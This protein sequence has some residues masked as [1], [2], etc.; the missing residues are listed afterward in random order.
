MSKAPYVG[1]FSS[2]GR[3]G[4]IGPG[5][6]R[7]VRDFITYMLAALSWYMAFRKSTALLLHITLPAQKPHFVAIGT[8]PRA[9]GGEQRDAQTLMHA[10]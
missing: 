10:A 9:G 5:L 7:D 4:N 8:A 1:R 2:N 6:G 3:S